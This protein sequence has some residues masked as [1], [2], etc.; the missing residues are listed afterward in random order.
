MELSSLLFFMNTIQVSIGE[1]TLFPR[2]LLAAHSHEQALELAHL[3]AATYYGDASSPLVQGG[4]FANGGEVYVAPGSLNSISQEAYM[5][6]RSF[7][8]FQE[9]EDIAKTLNALKPQ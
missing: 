5:E 9:P 2:I 3:N 1:Y 4:Y 8:P 6:L 7:M